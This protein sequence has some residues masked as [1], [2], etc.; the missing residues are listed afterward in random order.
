M[1]ENV[2]ELLNEPRLLPPTL[3]RCVNNRVSCVRED[4]ASE[5]GEKELKESEKE[6]QK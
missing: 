6:E 3:P 2:F 1:I 4:K 5:A